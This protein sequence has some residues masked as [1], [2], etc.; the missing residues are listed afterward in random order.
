MSWLLTPMPHMKAITTMT[1]STPTTISPVFMSARCL[2]RLEV[3]GKAER[4]ERC[5]SP[6]A[7]PPRAPVVV[8]ELAIAEAKCVVA[9]AGG[10]VAAAARRAH[11]DAI[12]A[13]QHVLAAMI[14]LLVVDA[15]VAQAARGAAREAGGGAARPL[16]QEADHEGAHGAALEEHVRAEPAPPV[17]IAARARAQALVV[18]EKRAVAL[19]HFHGRAGDIAGPGEDVLAV[20]G[21]SGAHAAVEEE[22]VGVGTP[23][24]ARPRLGYCPQG[25]ARPRHHLVGDDLM[26]CSQNHERHVVA[27]L[28]P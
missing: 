27:R 22:H 26:Q 16:R 8:A 7:R 1:T 2:P 28:C 9:G 25:R 3:V 14:D 5:R 13:L 24:V 12:A 19:G 18:E 23:V 20:L 21:G 11:E 15:H 6:G 10:A 17:P 4:V